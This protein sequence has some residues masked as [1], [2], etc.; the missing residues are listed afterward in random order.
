MAIRSGLPEFKEIKPL[1]DWNNN[2]GCV[3]MTYNAPLKKYILT[4]TD[5]W[6][7]VAKMNSYILESDKITG[8]WK[9]VAY[10]KDFGEQA[11]FLNFPSKF[12]SEDGKKL[13]LCYSGNFAKGWNNM[14]IK[15]YPPGSAYGL[16]MQEMILLDK[17]HL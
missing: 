11:Y 9:L 6:P 17:K 13:W 12:I 14:K 15:S 7:T 4:V 10:L 16:V 8:P 5:G 3:T 2:C 1:V